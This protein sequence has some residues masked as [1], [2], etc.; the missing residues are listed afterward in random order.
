[1]TS[2]S[3]ERATGQVVFVRLDDLLPFALVGVA[4]AWTTVA[5]VFAYLHLLSAA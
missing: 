2:I 3:N 5:K 4:L 1:M